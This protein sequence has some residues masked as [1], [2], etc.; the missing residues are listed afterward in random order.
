M[1]VKDKKYQIWVVQNCPC[2][3]CKKT[4]G[5]DNFFQ[6]QFHHLQ[7]KYRKGMGMRDD[8]LGLPICYHHHHELTFVRGERIY[9]QE[10]GIDPKIYADKLYKHYKENINEKRKPKRKNIRSSNRKKNN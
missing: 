2:Y 5:I 9:W 6:I 7:G 10:L 4:F 1:I 3:V 8:S